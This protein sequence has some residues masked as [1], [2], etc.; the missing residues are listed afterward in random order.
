MIRCKLAHRGSYVDVRRLFTHLQWFSTPGG[1]QHRPSSAAGRGFLECLV[2]PTLTACSDPHISAR[3]HKVGKFQL[4]YGRHAALHRWRFNVEEISQAL[5]EPFC[6]GSHLPLCPPGGFDDQA[7][8]WAVCFSASG[9][10]GRSSRLEQQETCNDLRSDQILRAFRLFFW[11]ALACQGSAS[12]PRRAAR[13]SAR[14]GAACASV[15]SGSRCGELF[16]C[17]GVATVR[18]FAEAQK[19]RPSLGPLVL[20]CLRWPPTAKHQNERKRAQRQTLATPEKG[21]RLVWGGGEGGRGPPY[22]N[23]SPTLFTPPRTLQQS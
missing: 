10:G 6:A 1:R 13:T 2:I 8:A 22:I 18:F 5:A 15:P 16:F 7:L 4:S 20:L 12:G 21:P 11:F 17:E 9:L 3:S 14:K 23:H 19:P